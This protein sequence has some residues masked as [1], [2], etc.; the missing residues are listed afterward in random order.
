MENTVQGLVPTQ[1]QSFSDIQEPPPPGVEDFMYKK[2]NSTF[3]DKLTIHISQPKA[4]SRKSNKP[5][6]PSQ[7]SEAIS[8]VNGSSQF[9]NCSG[10]LSLI[11]SELLVAVKKNYPKRVLDALLSDEIS[12][13]LAT[14]KE[15]IK[16]PSL[17]MQNSSNRTDCSANF[18]DAHRKEASTHLQLNIS[19]LQMSY[20][21]NCRGSVTEIVSGSV[22]D[23]SIK[24]SCLN[25]DASQNKILPFILKAQEM[26]RDL[27][28]SESCAVSDRNSLSFSSVSCFEDSTKE[29]MSDSGEE[30]DQH[31]LED[32]IQ[33]GNVSELEEEP[34]AIEN[35]GN[36]LQPENVSEHE[37]EEPQVIEN[38]GSCLQ[39]ENISEHEQ[40]L[41][42]IE[43]GGALQTHN[44]SF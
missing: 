18:E 4:V 17:E 23:T 3:E 16:V 1:V 8:K 5:M 36:C 33:P 38:R 20:S 34:Q 19:T 25:G 40:E 14:A 15:R 37:Q 43:N 26:L 41:Q 21:E 44:S 13:W 9:M 2:I 32:N 12:C 29:G 10:H 11:Q 7:N 35:R 42:V 6:T 27:E 28:R 30:V 39:P 22:P 24:E 31:V